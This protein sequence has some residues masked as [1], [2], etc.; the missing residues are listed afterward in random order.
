M[1]RDEDGDIDS[2]LLSTTPL[3]SPLTRK[4]NTNPPRPLVSFVPSTPS[5]MNLRNRHRSA[6]LLM[7]ALSAIGGLARAQAPLTVTSPDARTE[8]RVE[9]RDGH[10]MY[11]A[12][13]DR[14]DLLLPSLLGL[15]LG[16]AA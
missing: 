7:A 11:S 12:A 16:A 8:V 9:V 6:T 14:R 5:Q 4:Y 2:L 3:I 13:R 10:L 1:A 15:G